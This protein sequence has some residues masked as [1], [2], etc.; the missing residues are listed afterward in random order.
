[1]DKK[2]RLES[3]DDKL[4]ADLAEKDLLRTAGGYITSSVKNGGGV[5]NI[6]KIHDEEFDD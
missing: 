4:F 2:K 1:M 5:T 6:G 3:L